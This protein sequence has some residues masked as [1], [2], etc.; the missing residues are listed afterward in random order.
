VDRVRAA[1][2]GLTSSDVAY[3]VNMLAG[4]VDIA[5]YK[6]RPGRR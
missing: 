6:R 3:A 5:K 1:D 4:G 2:L